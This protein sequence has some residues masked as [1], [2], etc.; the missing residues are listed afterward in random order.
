MK[1]KNDSYCFRNVDRLAQRLKY[2]PGWSDSVFACGRDV[3]RGH[4]A[5]CGMLFA[6]DCRMNACT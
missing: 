1:V 3:D 2:L 5:H 4:G 6:A